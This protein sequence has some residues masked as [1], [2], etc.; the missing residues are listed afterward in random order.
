MPWAR[1]DDQ[2]PADAKVAEM[3]DRAFRA[4]FDGICHAAEKL[5]DGFIPAR[6]A[7]QLTGTNKVLKELV[8]SSWHPANSL[9][10]ECSK[11]APAVIAAA[12]GDGFY[13]HQYL[14]YNPTRAEVEED[15]RIRHEAKVRA[16][17]AGARARWGSDST[18]IADPIAGAM[19]GA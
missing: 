7:R 18:D 9:C 13:I 5:T 6:I 12:S 8:P 16:G 11:W 19:A 3:S 10:S 1:F 17:K 14:K 2:T 15:R 4:W